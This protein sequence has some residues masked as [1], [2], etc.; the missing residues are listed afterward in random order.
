VRRESFLSH[1]LP[2]SHPTPG[3]PGQRRCLSGQA[4]VGVVGAL[5]HV[6]VDDALGLGGAD[7]GGDDGL[8]GSLQS[9]G[10]SAELREEFLRLHVRFLVVATTV[11]LMRF[12]FC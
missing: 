2:F 12:L 6:G 10:A 8:R 7:G 4:L 3:S 5:L 9:A 11:E 1:L